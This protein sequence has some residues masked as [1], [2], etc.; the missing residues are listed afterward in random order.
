[1]SKTISLK[2]DDN[3]FNDI[4]RISTLF[5]MSSSEFIRNAVIREV[6]N[7]NN[8][9]IVRLSNVPLCDETEENEIKELLNNLNDDDIKI[10]KRNIIEL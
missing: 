5:N 3:L 4:K 2:M 8:D 9:F 10:V 1:M 7:K 6:A